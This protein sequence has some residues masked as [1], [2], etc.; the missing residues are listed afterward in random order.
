MSYQVKFRPPNTDVSGVSLPDIVNSAAGGMKLAND[1]KNAEQAM[2]NNA[3]AEKVTLAKLPFE[4][5]K[6]EEDIKK[7]IIDNK[8]AIALLP[9]KLR[10]SE[11]QA[12]QQQMIAYEQ[13]AKIEN[14]NLQA[15]L[16][17]EKNEYEDKIRQ[18]NILNQAH[19]NDW[20]G[21]S[22]EFIENPNWNSYSEMESFR[23]SLATSKDPTL[24]QLFNNLNKAKDTF[25]SGQSMSA[26]EYQYD[27]SPE[28]IIASER[29]E[30]MLKNDVDNAVKNGNPN[31]IAFR[32]AEL[33]KY[34]DSRAI[35][36]NALKYAAKNNRIK[37]LMEQGYDKESA[38]NVYEAEQLAVKMNVN[39]E[40]FFTT[41]RRGLTAGIFTMGDDLNELLENPAFNELIEDF[42]IQD[43]NDPTKKILDPEKIQVLANHIQANQYSL[44][45][46]NLNNQNIS[47]TN[48]EAAVNSDIAAVLENRPIFAGIDLT[49]ANFIQPY[50]A[51][52]DAGFWSDVVSGRAGGVGTAD[53]FGIMRFFS[54]FEIPDLVG[55]NKGTKLF[56]KT[57]FNTS[58]LGKAVDTMYS[59]KIALL[60]KE[61]QNA[62]KA[63]NTLLFR[64]LKKELTQTE[65]DYYSITGGLR[66][67]NRDTWSVSK[68]AREIITLL[69][70][71][72]RRGGGYFT[73]P[74]AL[75]N[76]IDE[77]V[78]IIGDDFTI[79]DTM[80]N[81][82]RLLKAKNNA[83]TKILNDKIA[84]IRRSNEQYL[85]SPVSEGG[86]T[87]EQQTLFNQQN[88]QDINLPNLD[89]GAGTA[90]Q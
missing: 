36:Q 61:I 7:Q 22:I 48:Q 62:K 58:P 73:N 21:K 23:K 43:P 32:K 41:V 83:Q 56:A 25:L 64:D 28:S 89:F 59:N 14:G 51:Q 67:Y 37:E 20:Y 39:N 1:I 71:A 40:S 60:Q 50:V 16:D 52:S 79:E 63:N 12:D 11:A 86:V 26:E 87:P 88:R 30:Q 49:D 66:G 42:K 38:E 65:D 33:K 31:E 18:Q 4:F 84:D 74:A 78:E 5:Q 10:L 80:I 9:S 70:D 81:S 69:D 6:L 47:L 90:G 82:I 44:E 17:Q 53:D 45:L 76:S 19:Q 54:K 27:G 57:I 75:Q 3:I 46:N 68:D 72:R 29:N 55:P 85:M 24:R 77:F 15:R 2:R 8:S 35:Q 34:T 13:A